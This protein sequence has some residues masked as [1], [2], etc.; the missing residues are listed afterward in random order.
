MGAIF[1]EFESTPEPP[2]PINNN[3]DMNF[4]KLTEQFNKQIEEYE[5]VQEEPIFL[6]KYKFINSKYEK[7][8]NIYNTLQKLNNANK[9]KTNKLSLIDY[10]NSLNKAKYEKCKT[11]FITILTKYIDQ[12]INSKLQ[13]I[14]ANNTKN[15]LK[16]YAMYYDILDIIAKN[17]NIFKI[18]SKNNKNS[19][20]KNLFFNI[21]FN[22]NEIKNNIYKNMMDEIPSIKEIALLKTNNKNI[23]STN[24]TN[25]I[26]YIKYE[27]IKI[28]YLI[29]YLNNN[30]Q[31][32]DIQIIERDKYYKYVEYKYKNLY[33]EIQKIMNIKK[34]NNDRIEQNGDNLIKGITPKNKLLYDYITNDFIGMYNKMAKSYN[35]LIL[36]INNIPIKQKIVRF[37]NK[38]Y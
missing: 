27:M 9:S 8:K 25:Y 11:D 14:E 13:I 22:P 6:Y 1:S 26:K 18:M 2:K 20:E 10:S 35:D 34:I 23:N 4:T 30:I 5:N 32:Y 38:K 31:K 12:N 15:K 24:L 36:T 17:E 16:I 19:F 7:L 3:K 37:N 29:Q 33:N 28:M 21:N